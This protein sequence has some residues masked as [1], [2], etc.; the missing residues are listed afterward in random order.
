MTTLITR[1]LA[2]EGTASEAASALEARGFNEDA[3]AVIS[4]SDASAAMEKSGV[5][6]EVASAYSSGLS[7]GN[8]LVAVRAPFGMA[9]AAVTALKKFKPI[10]VGLE[11]EESHISAVTDPEMSSSIIKGNKKFL[12]GKGVTE[13]GM[14]FTPFGFPMLSKRQKGRASVDTSTISAKFGMPLIKQPPR[15]K[16][17]TRNNPTPFSSLF[18]MKTIKQRRSSGGNSVI[19]DNPTP[20]SSALGWPTIADKE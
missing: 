9:G 10:D 3:V 11:S 7:S 14:R 2:D 20:L 6:E 8:A 19:S 15:K 18:G 12:T 16:S 1:L 4:G 13:S 17:L 5:S